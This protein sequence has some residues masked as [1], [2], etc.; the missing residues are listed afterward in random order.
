M[1][2][3]NWL[4]PSRSYS[5]P[6][7]REVNW[8]RC[9]P[10]AR[11][12]DPMNRLYPLVLEHRL[13][14]PVRYCISACIMVVCAVLQMALQMQT[15]VPGYFLLLPGVFLSR[16]I[17][18][19]GS[20]VFAA[21]MA[22]GVGAYLSYVGASVLISSRRMSFSRSPPPE[23]PSSPNSSTR[24]TGGSC[25]RTRPRSCCCRR[26]RTGRRTTSRSLAE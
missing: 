22:I 1:R 21:I 10:S 5:I 16:L 9:E 19:R 17:F 7:P 11:A 6:V 15:G 2:R 12:W 18:D 14:T 13:P 20:G 26:W 23:R 25:W 24:N 4:P 3:S 8:D